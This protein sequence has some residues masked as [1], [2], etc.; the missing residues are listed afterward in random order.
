VK[1]V[2]HDI[3]QDKKLIALAIEYVI[4]N[5]KGASLMPVRTVGASYPFEP[6][7][8]GIWVHGP[9]EEG[10]YEVT[11]HISVA[12]RT[13]PDAVGELRAKVWRELQDRN[14]V[15]HVKRFDV[16]VEDLMVAA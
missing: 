12:G 10:R 5:T 4:K 2:S 15:N 1:S 8:P 11:A 3:R 16:V 13:I 7:V 9:D 14:M 6:D